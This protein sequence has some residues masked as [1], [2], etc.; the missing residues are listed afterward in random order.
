MS[1]DVQQR[2][3]PVN[4]AQSLAEL[5]AADGAI[6]TA[7]D[8]DTAEQPCYDSRGV[9]RMYD[10]LTAVSDAMTPLG[11]GSYASDHE[12]GNGQF[13]QNCTY[14][15]A[16]TTTDRVITLRYVLQMLAQ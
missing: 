5:A 11:W 8:Q 13:E 6:V 7:D 10:H 15:D 12:D 3:A 1:T 14:A 4:T 2:E 9:T 16:L